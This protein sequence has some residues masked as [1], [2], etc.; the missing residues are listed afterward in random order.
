MGGCCGGWL[1][2]AGLG[3]R[4]LRGAARAGKGLLA[5]P[6]RVFRDGGTSARAGSA[7]GAHALRGPAAPSAPAASSALLLLFAEQNQSRN[8]EL[9]G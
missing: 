7:A 1:Y 2:T 9:T 6:P 8:S 4:G 3:E 5:E